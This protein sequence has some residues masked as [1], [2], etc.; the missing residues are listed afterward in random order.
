MKIIVS[1]VI[2]NMKNTPVYLFLQICIKLQMER[3]QTDSEKSSSRNYSHPSYNKN[4]LNN[5]E[6][7]LIFQKTR[8]SNTE[9]KITAAALMCSSK[10][11]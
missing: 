6:I 7:M 11:M 8:Y 2:Q 4:S 10:N 1:K 9:V 3:F 5:I